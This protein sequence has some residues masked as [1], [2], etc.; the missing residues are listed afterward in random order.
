[1]DFAK[2]EAAREKCRVLQLET[3]SNNEN[4]IAFYHSQGLSFFGFE[5]ALY[6]NGDIEDNKV[7]IELGMFLYS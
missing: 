3:H 5:K 7:C 6:S 4:A 2:E 1:M